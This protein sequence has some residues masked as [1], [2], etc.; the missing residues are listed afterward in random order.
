MMQIGLAGFGAIG[1]RV[2]VLVEQGLPGA[3]LA[4]ITSRDLDSARASARELLRNVPPV[5]SLDEAVARADVIVEAAPAAAFPAI[6]AAVLGRGKTLLAVSV[7]ALLDR[8]EEYTAAAA[9]HGGRIHIASGAIGGLDAIAAAREGRIESVTMVTRK[10]P[11][12]L[13]GAPYLEQHRIDVMALEQPAVVFDGTAREATRGFPANVNV[14]VAVSLAGIGP[15]RTRVRIIAD[16]TVTRNTHDVEVTGD[17]GRL[18][19]HI[20]NTPSANPRTGVLT[21]QSVVATLRKLISPV[22]IGT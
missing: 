21:A 3:A 15:D 6:A 7:G 16:P 20:E 18:T 8:Q 19:V 17:F 10:P 9:R 4:A 11:R 2:A 22:R 1:R 13:A 5:T 14:A 12:G